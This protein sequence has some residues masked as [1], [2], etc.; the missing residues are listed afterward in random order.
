MAGIYVSKSSGTAKKVAS[1]MRKRRG[2]TGKAAAAFGREAAR[3]G[4]A[5]RRR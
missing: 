4:G 5:R 3:R 2:M 1:K